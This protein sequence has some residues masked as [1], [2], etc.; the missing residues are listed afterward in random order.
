MTNEKITED[1]VVTTTDNGGN[2]LD[3]PKLPIKPK[4]IL[5]RY[6]KLKQRLSDDHDEH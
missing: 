5:T 2:G 1:V 6:K 3:T 4:N